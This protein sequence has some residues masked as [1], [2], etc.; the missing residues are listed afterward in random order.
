MCIVL[1][2]LWQFCCGERGGTAKPGGSRPEQER[3]RLLGAQARSSAP[4]VQHASRRQRDSSD[5]DDD[6]PSVQAPADRLP[7]QGIRRQHHIEPLPPPTATPLGGTVVV[8]RHGHRQDE[9]N[10]VWH[11]TAKRPWDPPLSSKGCTQVM[12]HHMARPAWWWW[13]SQP[14]PHE[15][16][17]GAAGT[18]LACRAGAP[19]HPRAAILGPVK[20]RP[21][22]PPPMQAHVPDTSCCRC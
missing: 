1:D 8:M 7:A 4:D 16:P 13:C 5:S 15:P 17:A 14:G 3:Q 9:A 18:R 21:P 11:K 10:P 2:A 19:G 6:M 20:S 12:I 22:P